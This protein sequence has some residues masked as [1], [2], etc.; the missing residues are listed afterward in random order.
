MTAESLISR[1]RGYAKI[2]ELVDEDLVATLRE[3]AREIE[4]L[5]MPPKEGGRT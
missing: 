2:Y 4:L 5:A 3:A 1:L